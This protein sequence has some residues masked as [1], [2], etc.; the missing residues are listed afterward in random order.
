MMAFTGCSLS[1]ALNMASGN[2]SKACLLN[3]RGTIETG[4]RADLILF[5]LDH[6]RIS[7]I[8]TIVK[9]RIAFTNR[10]LPKS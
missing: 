3:D 2:V 10:T 1:V 6:G 5:K 9:G 4:K 8:N 7:I